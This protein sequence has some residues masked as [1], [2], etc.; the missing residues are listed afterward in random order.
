MKEWYKYEVGFND[1]DCGSVYDRGIVEMTNEELKDAIDNPDWDWVELNEGPLR[2]SDSEVW[3]NYYRAP[4]GV[5][6]DEDELLGADN[7]DLICAGS[8]STEMRDLQLADLK[9][10]YAEAISDGLNRHW[11][12]YLQGE[13]TPD[14]YVYYEPDN[15]RVVVGT[16]GPGVI[17][18][19]RI[20]DI[21]DNN[22]TTP[23]DDFDVVG[24]KLANVWW[25]EV[26]EKILDALDN[27]EF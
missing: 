24:A 16:Y 21:V 14:E 8:V 23:D 13:P 27:W 15:N 26:E 10:Q 1:G 25:K 19:Q 9:R 4:D 2:L 11:G 22:N 12:A 3:C 18:I 17:K 5:E 6:M 7:E 20:A